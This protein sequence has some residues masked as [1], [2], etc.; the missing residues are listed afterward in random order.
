M[1]IHTYI[2][3]KTLIQILDV[4]VISMLNLWKLDTHVFNFSK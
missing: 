3:T 2:I 4:S 1:V